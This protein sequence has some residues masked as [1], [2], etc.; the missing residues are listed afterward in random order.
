METAALPSLEFAAIAELAGVAQW[1]GYT[2]PRKVPVQPNGQAARS[3]DPETWCSFE[4]CAAAV[5]SGRVDGVGF[6]F[7]AE[8]DFVGIDLDH[9]LDDI[10][11]IRDERIADLVASLDSYTEVS[12]SGD[13]LHVWVKGTIPRALK[14]APIEVY[15]V[16]RY[17]TVTGR[18][19]AGTPETIEWRQDELD[20][21]FA[22]HAT[23]NRPT[24]HVNG[25]ARAWAHGTQHH[26][27]VS[28]AGKLR[29]VGLDPEEIEPALQAV[30]ARRCEIP[31]RPENIARIAHDAGKWE[32]GEELD[33]AILDHTEIGLSGEALVR[34]ASEPDPVSP[35]TGFLDP[36]PSLHLLHGSAKT[37]KTTLAWLVALAWAQ[38][39]SPWPT[40][41]AL[42]GSRVLILSAEQGSRKCLRV[43]RRLTGS[44]HLGGFEGW[45]SRITIVG[46]HGRMTD[47]DRALLTL[48]PGGLDLL[49]AVLEDAAQQ[50]QPFG[51]VVADSLSRLKPGDAALNDNDDMLRLL[52]PLAAICQDSGAYTLLIHHA[53]HAAERRGDPINGVRG[54]SAIR[55]VPQALWSVDRV[56]GDPRRRVV[57]VAGNEV[58]DGYFDFSVSKH[59]EPDGHVNRFHLSECRPLEHLEAFGSGPLNLTE[60]GRAALGWAPDGD[61]SGAAKKRARAMLQELVNRG[62]VRRRGS[63]WE[64]VD[65]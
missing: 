63:E 36:E 11:N 4:E 34:L 45:S 55:D 65:D 31:G 35:L 41:P 39:L 20:R 3:N 64:R 38:R 27:L 18:H 29:R 6:V 40:A 62:V 17:F 23:P 15:T 58:P 48:D 50:G 24:E 22:E 42:P 44:A 25:H 14:V 16:G 57:R 60:F 28:L 33:P 43:L 46:R 49:R 37:G 52:S 7:S 47:A 8:D 30:N 59:P 61:P 12:P 32:R 9:V 5:V 1:V 10:G 56:E 26:Q 54:A 51:L 21:L 13:G 19:F 53:G 2:L